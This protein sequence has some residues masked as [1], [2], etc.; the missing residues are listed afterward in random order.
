MFQ[1]NCAKNPQLK[2]IV[3]VKFPVKGNNAAISHV[4]W[5]GALYGVE[6][7]QVLSEIERLDEEFA[8]ES[9]SCVSM[10]TDLRWCSVCGALYP[11]GRTK[12]D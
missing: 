11:Q 2:E 12:R 8:V 5:L 4:F 10:L 1:L 3:L 6:L 7:C 9:Y